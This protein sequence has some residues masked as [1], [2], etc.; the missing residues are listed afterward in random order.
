MVAAMSGLPRAA[1]RS[2]VALLTLAF[3]LGVNGLVGAIHSVHHLPAP[4]KALA[5][6]AHGHGH[7]EQDPT[8]T[9][10]PQDTCPVAAAALHLAGTA[11]EAPPAFDPSPAEATLVALGSQD[12][13]HAT[14]RE[15]ARGRAPPSRGSLPS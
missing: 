12:S 8:P 13:P 11:V 15:P 1:Q 6:D 3:V 2:L 5:H 9:G 14:W 4:A 10:A 7:D